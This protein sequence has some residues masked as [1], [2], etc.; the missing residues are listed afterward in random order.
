MNTPGRTVTG[1][2]NCHNNAFYLERMVRGGAAEEAAQPSPQP[3]TEPV[4]GLLWRPISFPKSAS[5]KARMARAAAAPPSR[6]GTPDSGSMA[7]LRGIR[8]RGERADRT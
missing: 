4:L 8:G 6:E 5:A 7:V 1:W 2:W 3:N